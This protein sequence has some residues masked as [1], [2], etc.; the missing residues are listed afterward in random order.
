MVWHTGRTQTRCKGRWTVWP[1]YITQSA[2]SA[3]RSARKACWA[4]DASLSFSPVERNRHHF[5]GLALR[6]LEQLLSPA[7]LCRSYKSK[8]WGAPHQLG[9]PGTD[10]FC[11]TQALQY[12]NWESSSNPGQ[13]WSPFG[14]LF[15]VM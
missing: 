6:E 1:C 8:G 2:S 3:L 13:R 10:S 9:L 12:C 4:F 5:A 14:T 11:R 15:W 7:C